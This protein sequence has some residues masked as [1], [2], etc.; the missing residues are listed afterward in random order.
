MNIRFVEDKKDSIVFEIEGV[1]HGFCNLLKDELVKNQSVK[2]A[3]YRIDH[4]VV[5]VPRMMV[6][7]DDPKESVKAAIK[8][9][10]KTTAD[11][12]KEVAK[13]K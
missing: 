2:I 3:T 8:A 9:L 5:G 12:K 1:S 4:P 10:K 13:L 7:G 11:F 6:E